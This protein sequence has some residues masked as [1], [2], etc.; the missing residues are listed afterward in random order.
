MITLKKSLVVHMMT[1]ICLFMSFIC[2]IGFGSIFPAIGRLTVNE[3]CQTGFRYISGHL[4]R[5]FFLL[6][7]SKIIS[8]KKQRIS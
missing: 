2:V 1:F 6:E 3:H 8:Y 5:F 7:N 4:K